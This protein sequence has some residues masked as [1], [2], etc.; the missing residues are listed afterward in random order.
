[1]EG[2]LQG[3]EEALQAAADRPD[4]HD[5]V[6]AI[7]SSVAYRTAEA[8]VSFPPKRPTPHDWKLTWREPMG[9][10][11]LS[12]YDCQRCGPSMNSARLLSGFGR[13]KSNSNG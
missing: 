10:G 5:D 7:A 11:H 2:K 3:R 6:M 1:V 9:D 8:P 13:R 12:V 4:R